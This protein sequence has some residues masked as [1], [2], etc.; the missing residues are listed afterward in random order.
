VSAASNRWLVVIDMQ[1]VFAD[2]SSGWAAPQFATIVPNMKT[3]IAAFTPQVIFTRFVVPDEPVGAW[4]DYYARW[5]FARDP[6]AA[7]FFDLV[8]DLPSKG[9]PVIDL[10]TFGKWGPALRDV[11]QQPTALVLAGVS[12]DCCVLSTALA[13]ADDGIR[14]EVVVDACAGATALDHQRALDAMALYAP[15]VVL[16]D[17]ATAIR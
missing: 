7:T 13:A 12:T 17:T 5:P 8:S 10:P 11:A 6:S 16:T 14:V 2:P 9:H 4:A 15:L 3:L 1:N